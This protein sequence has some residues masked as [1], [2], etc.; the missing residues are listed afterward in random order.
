MSPARLVFTRSESG[1]MVARSG[2]V[3]IPLV[4]GTSRRCSESTSLAEKSSARSR[5]GVTPSARARSSDSGLDQA[6]T[7][8]PK[9]RPYAA[10]TAPMRP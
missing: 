1:R 10:T 5:A 4:A 3:T 2:A 7:S 6:R 8:I 9:A